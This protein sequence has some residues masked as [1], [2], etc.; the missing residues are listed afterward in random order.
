MFRFNR[1]K[2]VQIRPLGI[3][4]AQTPYPA[5]K[6]ESRAALENIGHLTQKICAIWGTEDLDAFLSKQQDFPWM[7]S[8][9][10]GDSS[11]TLS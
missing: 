7:F 2:P 9:D 11:I 8:Q 1:P 5:G 4:F 10:H 6:A 3:M